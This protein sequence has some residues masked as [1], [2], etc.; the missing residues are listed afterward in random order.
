MQ[1]QTIKTVLTIVATAVIAGG[2]VYYWQQQKVDRFSTTQ[3]VNT[4]TEQLNKTQDENI[5]YT[6]KAYDLKFKTTE[7]CKDYLVVKSVKPDRYSTALMHYSVFVPTSKSWPTDYAWF[8]YAIYSQEEYNKFNPNELP[9]Q[10]VKILTLDSG[11]LL[12]RWDPQDL[13]GDVPEGCGIN[14]IVIEEL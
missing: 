2:A 10:P 6:D 1:S 13:P 5:L 11:K 9:G 3:N 8:R 12:A 7:K 4:K 14:S